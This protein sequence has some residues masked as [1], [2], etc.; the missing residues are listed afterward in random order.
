MR[1]SLRTAVVLVLTAVGAVSAVVVGNAAHLSV[2]AGQLSVASASHPCPGRTLAVS[3]APVSGTTSVVSVTTPAD[4]PAAC[5]GERVDVVVADGT[6]TRTGSIAS[7]PAAGTSVNV[8]LSGAFTPAPAGVTTAAVVAGWSLATSWSYAPPGNPFGTCVIVNPSGNPIAG[9]TCTVTDLRMGTYWGAD[10]SRTANMYV[11]FSST[12]VNGN[13]RVQFSLNLQGAQGVPASWSW[14]TSGSLTGGNITT[15][16]GYAC[17]ELPVLRGQTPPGWGS[18][19]NV[20]F[21]VAENRATAS[22]LSCS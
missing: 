1:R 12:G 22:G 20:F 4:W 6:V 9:Q 8:T 11:S 3:A 13:Q 10:G 16:S 19:T 2:N 14:A 18:Y 15:L 17:S 21:Q 7:A 5:V